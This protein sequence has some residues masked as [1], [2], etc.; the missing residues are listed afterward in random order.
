M[1]RYN[2]WV[3]FA[4]VVSAVTAG[5]V[6]VPAGPVWEGKPT[7]GEPVLLKV[8]N[9]VFLDVVIY[10]EVSGSRVRLGSVSSGFIGTFKIPRQHQLS[11]SLRLVA[12]PIG[13]RQTYTSE[14]IS[15]MPGTEIRWTVHENA[16]VRALSIW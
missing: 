4:I 7:A 5:C 10:S 15:A 14:P 11:S 12:D 2:R 6:S 8:E 3:A 9:R 13:S 16:G 1:F